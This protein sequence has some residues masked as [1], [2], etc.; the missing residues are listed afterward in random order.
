MGEY[1]GGG[2]GP[3]RN[4]RRN[5][6]G[7]RKG[8][9]QGEYT[10][11]RRGGDRE[12]TA[13]SGGPRGNYRSSR[14][15]E[16]HPGASNDGDEVMG[17]N[18]SNQRRD[19]F[20]PYGGG[21]KGRAR[22]PRTGQ[23]NRGERGRG[24]APSR[25]SVAFYNVGSNVDQSAFITFLS[26]MINMP[27]F[28]YEQLRV[29]KTHE[30][31]SGINMETDFEVARSLRSLDGIKYNSNKLS[32]KIRPLRTDEPANRGG[33][34]GF[35]SSS[36]D[37]TPQ[38]M[39]ELIA[40]LGARYNAEAQ[41]IGL[42]SLEEANPRYRTNDRCF[43]SALIKLLG[44]NC[45]NVESIDIS[46]NKISRLEDW[47][48][49][50]KALP[51]LKNLHLGDNNIRDVREIDHLASMKGS[52]MEL[53][54]TGNPI[55]SHETYQSEVRKRFPKLMMLDMVALP[56]PVNF[57]LPETTMPP[58]QRF[59]LNVPETVQQQIFSFLESY[60][61]LYDSTPVGRA[62][63]INAYGSNATFSLSVMDRG[64]NK[65]YSRHGFYTFNR[66]LKRVD[67]IAKRSDLL[68]TSP[69]DIISVL[70]Q[71]PATQHDL[72]QLGVDMWTLINNVFSVRLSGPF[73][74]MTPTQPKNK[75]RCFHRTF[76]LQFDANG[77]A[78]IINDVLAILPIDYN[79]PP[80]PGPT[81]TPA[82]V[83]STAPPA[84]TP[85]AGAP[86]GIGLTPEM[87][88]KIRTVIQA[89]RLTDQMANDLLVSANWDLN[90]AAVKF[91]A[92]K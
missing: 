19:R 61:N 64:S 90:E 1:E 72:Q 68:Y 21:R 29:F 9:Y 27:R 70:K 42:A 3:S 44:D 59:L 65:S 58:S 26:K 6:R 15:N 83:Q 32:V 13:R 45:P 73:I 74:E 16:K 50:G 4:V 76:V 14:S 56:P 81:A 75:D 55:T 89:T 34:K 49:L 35:S 48:A 57:M 23:D 2:G 31:T 92:A 18:D 52:V 88:E 30:G 85:V 39:D 60:Y 25:S 37:L 82:A 66:N 80:P 77:G 8:G 24:R 12:D 38:E 62:D 7:P 28:S 63:L 5:G 54:L 41:L 40:F 46:K 33:R 78:Q 79:A 53:I 47:R 20:N 51:H 11:D 71:L 86:Q 87:Q 43:I 84:S 69:V 36:K 67:N 91:E 22:G 17:N 10:D